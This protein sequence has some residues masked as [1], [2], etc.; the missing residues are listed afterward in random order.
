MEKYC[1][2][3]NEKKKMETIEIIYDNQDLNWSMLMNDSSER[4]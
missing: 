4:A 1:R 3:I 2:E